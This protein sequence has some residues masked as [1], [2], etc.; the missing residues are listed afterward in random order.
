[1]RHTILPALAFYIAAIACQPASTELTEEQKAAIADSVT[2]LS[3]EMQNAFDNKDAAYFDYFLP[4]I[5][6]MPRTLT[7][8]PTGLHPRRRAT[9]HSKCPVRLFRRVSGRTTPRRLNRGKH[10]RGCLVPMRSLWN[11]R[12]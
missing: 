1:M 9:V 3:A 4:L 2:Q 11:V 5:T 10:A 12:K 6:K 7:I 8:S